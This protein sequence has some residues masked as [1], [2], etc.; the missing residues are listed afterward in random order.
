MLWKFMFVVVLTL[1]AVTD[2]PNFEEFVKTYGKTYSVRDLTRSEIYYNNVKLIDI[3]N[4][5]SN[6]TY[7]LG[8]NEWADL[9]WDEFTQFKS[10]YPQKYPQGFIDYVKPLSSTRI[11]AEMNW[12][13]LGKVTP[14]KDQSNCG[15]CWAFSAISAVESAL[16]IKTN[17]VQNLSEQ[18]LVDCDR[19][20]NGC[21][22][23]VMPSAFTYI[24]KNG[25][26]L[27]RNYPYT[28]VK[29][30]C[31]RSSI[32]TKIKRYI[33][34]RA[35]IRDEIY[36]LNAVHIQ[37]VSVG[38]EADELFRFYSSGIYDS[39]ICTRRLNHAVNIVGYT[40]DYWIVR[41]SWGEQWGE[42]GYIRMIRNKNIC[43]INLF[44]SYPVL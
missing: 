1:G 43:G 23:G 40:P 7:K 13:S 26:S 20:N 8:V 15:S 10:L 21:R 22:G 18:Q 28:G 33:N 30:T 41:N 9:T 36:L 38:I 37:P 34:V 19:A 31:F 25:I 42:S 6:H 29:Q 12:V 39:S 3:H 17:I 24:A 5:N 32:Y 16:A 35:S 4:S 44:A 27:S 2:Y 11:P 14:I